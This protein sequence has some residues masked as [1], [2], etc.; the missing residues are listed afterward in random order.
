MKVFQMIQFQLR[1]TIHTESTEVMPF[2]APNEDIIRC[3]C[4]LYRDE[5]LMR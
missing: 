1:Q 5:G 3:I 2:F 4:G